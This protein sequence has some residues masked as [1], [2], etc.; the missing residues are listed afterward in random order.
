MIHRLIACAAFAL[1]LSALAPAAHASYYAYDFDNLGT[2]VRLTQTSVSGFSGGQLNALAYDIYHNSLTSGGSP[3]CTS[4][5]CGYPA[6]C[7]NGSQCGGGTDG[8][9][10][11]SGRVDKEHPFNADDSNFTAG[12]PGQFVGV[13]GGYLNTTAQRVCDVLE[14]YDVAT[15]GGTS[16]P[17]TAKAT[18]SG[19]PGDDGGTRN[20]VLYTGSGWDLLESNHDYNGILNG[21]T[22]RYAMT[23]LSCVASGA[24]GKP[25]QTLTING[26]SLATVKPGQTANLTWSDNDLYAAAKQTC[27]ASVSPA[28]ATAFTVP[29]PAA[30]LPQPDEASCTHA[31]GTFTG[32]P[33]AVS[34][35]GQTS[36]LMS[37]PRD[38]A[39]D[40]LYTYSCDDSETPWLGGGV[41]TVVSQDDSCIHGEGG[42]CSKTVE[43]AVALP[44]NTIQVSSDTAGTYTYDYTC[45]N[46]N[47]TIDVQATLV[48]SGGS[49]SG[50]CTENPSTPINPGDSVT[51]A[52]TNVTGGSGSYS[53]SWS[54]DDGMSGAGKTVSHTYANAGTY[55][56][57][58]VVV[59]DKNDSNIHK[60]LKCADVEV[61][62]TAPDLKG[63]GSVTYSAPVISGISTR[64]TQTVKNAGAS[65]TGGKFPVLFRY[66]PNA[67]GSGDTPFDVSSSISAS[68]LAAGAS[69]DVS[70]N[71]STT[72]AGTF[73]VQA[74]A[75]MDAKFN[76]P[77]KDGSGVQSETVTDNN[78]GSWTKVKVQPFQVACTSS[79]SI[80]SGDQGVWTASVTGGLSPY[81]YAWNFDGAGDCG[82]G[83]TGS[84]KTC[85]EDL[86]NPPQDTYYADVAVFDSTGAE[87]DVPTTS[88]API[89]VAGSVCG[90]GTPSLTATPT[91]VAAGTQVDLSWSDSAQDAGSCV[92]T[93]DGADTGWEADDQVE[94]CS[95]EGSH[96]GDIVQA[97]TKYCF[98]CAGDGTP[99]ACQIVNVTPGFQEY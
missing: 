85:K 45:T 52:A 7:Y 94:G 78:C 9:G 8:K 47:G 97:Q 43:C 28:G 36:T 57:N 84:S 75:N 62:S 11:F 13:E 70:F 3:A 48:V 54:G 58:Q 74:C 31:G 35:P 1:A 79:G 27:T 10:D 93:K 77:P 53:Y 96:D 99:P 5:N 24:S 16:T 42:R 46:A 64:Y 14:A 18:G 29:T 88:C 91:R 83:S 67:D 34:D 44:G 72:T 39:G 73:Y 87:V 12:Y 66:S 69:E 90:F 82:D 26:G 68:K 63:I 15:Y 71:Y 4:G 33:K 50:S 76:I 80:N 89:T 60:T 20:T 22:A 81:T 49:I 98:S 17:L 86:F 56:N 30:K 21:N 25:A 32:N 92:V 65:T 55:G 41:C 51:F 40:P 95:V 38:D 6:A 37:V 23:S 19:D 61:D 59:T 2:A